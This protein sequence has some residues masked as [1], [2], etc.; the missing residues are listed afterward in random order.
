MTITSSLLFWTVKAFCDLTSTDFSEHRSYC[1][2]LIYCTPAT[3]AFLMFFEHTRNAPASR[4]Q[5]FPF[6]L[7]GRF[8]LP[9]C[10]WPAPRLLLVCSPVPLQGG[11][12]GHSTRNSPVVSPLTLLP[13]FTFPPWH[14]SCLTWMVQIYLL[15][16]SL[17]RSRPQV[18]FFPC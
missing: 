9:T 4:T 11:S 7:S 18:S 16:I 10:Q 8:F 14:M 13:C 5:H 2:C 6:P 3:L 1:F 15:S 17:T 12:P